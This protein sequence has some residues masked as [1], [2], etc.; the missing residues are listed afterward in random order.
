MGEI[1]Y[2]AMATDERYVPYCGVAIESIICNANQDR[3]YRVF[4]LHDGLSPNRTYDLDSMSVTNVSIKCLDIHDEAKRLDV[5][6]FNHVTIA[7]AYR[8]LVPRLLPDCK[9]VLWIDVDAV[10][11]YDVSKLYD[12]NITD[13]ILGVIQ[14]YVASDNGFMINHLNKTLGISSEEFFNAGVLVIN[15]ERFRD[16][17]LEK[18]CFDLLSKRPDYIFTDQDVLNVTCKGKVKYLD[19]KWNYEWSFLFCKADNDREI[20]NDA[21][22]IHYAGTIKPWHR[23]EA[24][25]AQC[26]W[27]YAR[28]TRFY[29]EIILKM[30]A[31]VTSEVLSIRERSRIKKVAVYGAGKEGRAVVDKIERLGLYQ[32]AAWVDRDWENKIKEGIKVFPIEKIFNVKWDALLIAIADEE[33]VEQVKH[34]LVNRGVDTEKIIW[35]RDL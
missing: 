33:I 24:P 32:I 13:K 19:N 4:V 17:G 6:E 20:D 21:Y 27:H 12:V 34:D 22:I 11:R 2:I 25:L 29:E 31:Y 9:K 15:C 23:P 30:Q 14:G 1:V 16:E 26:F 28:Q 5:K 18:K 7:S 3:Q 10:A 8:L 35:T